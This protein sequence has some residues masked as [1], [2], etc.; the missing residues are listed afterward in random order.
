MDL[1]LDRLEA[2]ARAA[3]PGEWEHSALRFS[4][5][6][7]SGPICALVDGEY[8][9]NPKFREDGDHIKAFQPIHALS[10]LATIRTLT[11]ERDDLAEA[12]NV[13]VQPQRARD[14]ITRAEA[15]EAEAKGL[16][17]ALQAIV[18]FDDMP[19]SHKRPDVFALRLRRARTALEAR[20]G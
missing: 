9:E 12:F 13:A 14:L 5:N 3:T 15:A 7:P 10:L 4:I 17:E 6:S 11:K 16:W 20:H 8:M 18:D 1:D 19:T 2:I